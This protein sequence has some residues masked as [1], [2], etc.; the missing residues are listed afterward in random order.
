MGAMCTG[1]S[2]ELRS[3]REDRHINGLDR[4]DE[5]LRRA[6]GRVRQVRDTL[7][8]VQP[9]YDSGDVFLGPMIKVGNGAWYDGELS[10][11]TKDREGFGA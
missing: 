11:Q 2:E 5:I 3:R 10:K 7:D 6:G 8:P 9:N 1:E 4:D